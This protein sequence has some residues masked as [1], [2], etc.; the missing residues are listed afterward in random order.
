MATLSDPAP[1]GR[2]LSAS[3]A[4]AAPALLA[5]PRLVDERPPSTPKSSEKRA[6]DVEALSG[7]KRQRRE[8][9]HDQELPSCQPLS[10]RE[11]QKEALGTAVYPGRGNNVVYAAL[12]LAGES[13]EVANKV[14]KV[15]RDDGGAFTEER[16]QQVAD[17]VGDVLW[18]A[19]VLASELGVDLETIAARNLCKL[20]GRRERGTLQGSGDNR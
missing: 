14:K 1:C 7:D 13:G 19:A 9:S 8:G 11:Y 17:E 12:G 6:R 2:P 15:L 16:K 18:Y 10:L 5:C 4:A 20:R 3:A